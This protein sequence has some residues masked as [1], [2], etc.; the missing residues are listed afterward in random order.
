MSSFFFSLSF[1]LVV[2]DACASRL[3]IGRER[4]IGMR[5]DDGTET[6]QIAAARRWDAVVQLDASGLLN[7]SQPCCSVMRRRRR[8]QTGRRQASQRVG[9]KREGATPG[10]L[11]REVEGSLLSRSQGWQA[12]SR[13]GAG[14]GLPSYPR[15]RLYSVVPAGVAMLLALAG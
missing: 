14:G 9:F 1:R 4:E 5:N 11:R 12:C 7:K 13:A 8:A 3:E 10:E 2:W 15:R 6:R